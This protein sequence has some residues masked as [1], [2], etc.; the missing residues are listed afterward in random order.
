MVPK[1]ILRLGLVDF[2]WWHTLLD[3]GLYGRGDKR[4]R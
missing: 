3:R 1:M 2:F 4:M